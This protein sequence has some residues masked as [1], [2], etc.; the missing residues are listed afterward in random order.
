MSNPEDPDMY[1]GWSSD[2]LASMLSGR[3]E[4]RQA[5]EPLYMPHGVEQ[6]GGFHSGSEEYVVDP[7]FMEI[8]G[9]SDPEELVRRKMDISR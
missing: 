1:G 6:S 2:D 8:M 4:N 7:D 5:A 3:E 9:I